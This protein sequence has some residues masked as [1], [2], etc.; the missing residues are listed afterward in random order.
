MSFLSG[1]TLIEVTGDQR[2][3][4]FDVYFQ[5]GLFLESSE[6]NTIKAV[7]SGDTLTNIAVRQSAII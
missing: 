5:D 2:Y 4:R 3:I 6:A 7:P 1:A